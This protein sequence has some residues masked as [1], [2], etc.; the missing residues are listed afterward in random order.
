VKAAE[1]D[2]KRRERENIQFPTG[3]VH[4][5]GRLKTFYSAQDLVEQGVLGEGVTRFFVDHVEGAEWGSFGNNRD[6]LGLT[7]LA[8]GDEDGDVWLPI[9]GARVV[10][11]VQPDTVA[12]D[13]CTRGDGATVQLPPMGCALPAGTKLR[14]EVEAPGYA[15]ATARVVIHGVQENVVK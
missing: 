5:I 6:V 9:V 12:L 4:E 3:P 2:A 15:G 14:V 1:R 7:V 10:L 8:A 13:L 11:R